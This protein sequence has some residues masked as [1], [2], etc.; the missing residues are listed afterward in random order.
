MNNHFF[1]ESFEKRLSE[2]TGAPYVVLTD[3]CTNAL[4]ITLF[5]LKKYKELKPSNDTIEIPR[6]NYISVP[7]QIRHLGFSIKFTDERWTGV[8]RLGETPVYDAAQRFTSDMYI[9]NSFMCLS[10]QQK[11]ILNIGKGGAILLNKR[12]DRD[13]LKRLVW[14]GRDASIPVRDDR[15]I[16]MGFH[17]N[18]TP[19]M[20]ASGL[21]KLNALPLQN[22]DSRMWRDYPDISQYEVFKGG[23][24]F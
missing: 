22:Q 18:M 3:S 7:M 15:K 4:F 23:E 13:I 11:K 24:F 19:D 10:F 21:L 8:Y 2:Y 5:F 6:F 9:E 20:A 17:M 12:E 14:D 1:I 16:I